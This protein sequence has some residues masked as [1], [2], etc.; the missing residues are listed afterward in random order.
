VT[1]ARS[2]GEPLKGRIL[3]PQQ[4]AKKWTTS[5]LKERSAAQEHFLDLCHMLGESTPAEVD[6][7]GE[8]YCFERGAKKTGGGDGWADVWRKGHFAWEYKGKHKDLNVAFS[9]LQRYAIALENPPLLVVSDMARIEVHT[10]FTNTVQEIHVIPVD[11]IGVDNNLQ[12]LKCLFSDPEALKPGK[13]KEAITEEAA[14]RFASLAKILRERGG[15]PQRVAHFLNRILFCLFAQDAKLLPGS[16]V[17]ELLETGVRRPDEANKM[18]RTLFATMKKGGVFGTHVIEWFNGNLFDSSD[19]V[20]LESEDI[21]ALL[22]VARLD[23]SAIEPSIFGTLFER[24][25]D[26]DK[27]AQIGAHYTDPTS[28]MDIIRPVVIAPL[29]AEWEKAKLK[30]ETLCNG[31]VKKRHPSAYAKSRERAQ[32][33]FNAFLHS[34]SEFRVLDPACGSGNFLYLA[35]QALKDL[36]HRATLEAEQLGLEASFTGMHVGVRCVRGIELNTYAAEL[37]RV[38]VWIGEIQWMLRHGVRPS[39]DPILKPLDTIEHRDAILNRDGSEPE[40]PKADAI[41]GNPP[42]LGDKKMRGALGKE[43]VRNLRALY[44]TSVPGGADFVTYWF[45]KARAQIEGEKTKRAGLV[46]TNSIRG[47]ASRRVLQR[48]GEQLEIFDAWSDRPW[49]N[50]GAAV[51]VSL[52]CFRIRSA[53]DDVP[54][55]PNLDGNA[56]QQIYPD[57]R[58]AAISAIGGSGEGGPADLTL[59]K[60]LPEDSDC[61]FIGT[62]KNGPF[63]I[64]G[65]LARE[66]LGSP[67]PGGRHNEDVLKPW[68]NGLDITR[69]S[70]D[71]WVIDFGVHMREEEAALY[72]KP[73]AYVR[74]HVKPMRD[75]VNRSGHRKYW[76]RHGETR[77]GLRKQMARISRYIAIP[78]VAKHRVFVW[79]HSKVLPD[80]QIVAV[81]RADDATFG[82]LHS[83]FHTIWSLKMGTSLEDRPR[84]TPT[85][86]FETFPFP[87]GLSPKVTSAGQPENAVIASISAAARRLSDLRSGWLNPPDWV[88][89]IPEVLPGYADRIVAQPGRETELKKRTLTNL[90]NAQP[91]WLKDA[92]CALDEAVA[93]AYG[94]ADYTPSMSDE[95]ILARLLQLNLDRAEDLFGFSS[96]QHSPSAPSAKVNAASARAKA[97]K[98]NSV[99]LEQRLAVICTLVNRLADDINFGRTKMAKLFYLADVTQGLD[100]DTQYYR[101]AAGPLD[102]RALYHRR[103]GIEALAVQNNYIVVS[104]AGAKVK[105]R[106]GSRITAGMEMAKEILGSHRKPLNKMIDLFRPL[107]TRQCEIVATLYACWNDVLI[108][109]RNAT[110]EVIVAEFLESWHERK[111]RFPKARL[112]KALKWMRT[113]GLVPI[114]NGTHTARRDKNAGG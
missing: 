99:A 69:R 24:G 108:E 48:F 84:Y 75:Q 94:W 111:R 103:T 57:L 92:H 80:C 100:L 34:L 12:L 3:T 17:V 37:A 36:E 2:T 66:W 106:R 61:S 112:L 59:A 52:I 6:P 72:E 51:R 90:Y 33:I 64:P 114:G 21:A 113:H 10:N 54:T 5:T 74:K 13:T 55:V 35:L 7:H 71:L 104:Q 46:A 62:Q 8:W 65:A 49:I 14:Q 85:T 110:D 20:P 27:R 44:D 45:D 88:Q 101:E 26:P 9:Q 105:Y 43:Y 98:P 22:T 30:I 83:R 76:W 73:Y 16:I 31:G 60:R 89:R 56:V 15:E 77:S 47:G 1:H 82:V 25:L 109:R 93:R 58:G 70:Q 102:I 63:E 23:W 28:I 29:S 97:A 95:E 87:S 50:E 67:N 32:Q 107:D 86:S 4:F 79:V 42:F 11:Q 78:R 96:R 53:N 19:A 81:T 41:I 18:L 91:K 39:R 38:T 68:A 40:W